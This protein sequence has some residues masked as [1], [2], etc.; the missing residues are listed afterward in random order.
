MN[1]T[2]N[3][4][5]QNGTTLPEQS[6][7]AQLVRFDK[8]LASNG[9]DFSNSYGDDGQLIFDLLF[10][11]TLTYQRD[12]FG[13]GKLIPANFCEAM[14]YNRLNLLKKHPKPA[15]IAQSTQLKKELAKMEKEGNYNK[16][17]SNGEFPFYT[18]LDNA[19]YRAGKENLKFSYDVKNYLSK[20]N[21]Q[22]MKFLPL[23]SDVNK[24]YTENKNK[25]YYTYKLSTTIE[26]HLSKYFMLAS[27]DAVKQLR[28]QNSV[29][30]YFFLKNL[31]QN[32][33]IEGNKIGTPYFD[34]L[35]RIAE[36]HIAAPKDRKKKLIKKL[37]DLREK[38][39]LKFDFRFVKGKGRF[40]YNIEIEFHANAKAISKEEKHEILSAAFEDNYLHGIKNYFLEN[41]H[42]KT[43]LKWKDW[44]SNN[45]Y[46][47]KEK[48]EIFLAEHNKMFRPID[49]HSK[50][51]LT[52]FQLNVMPF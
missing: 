30:L 34:L 21:I 38:T 14:G 2:Q 41:I 5:K 8:N 29:Y 51:V 40:E 44:K 33:R 50:T 19:F 48:V 45:K 46:N 39:D 24:H 3:S 52:Y 4:E 12:L 1:I 27:A 16:K 11:I 26:A 35:C 10:Y 15:Q 47:L 7:Q 17:M 13:Y 22:A 18:V 23:L 20:E 9:L 32:L 43:S 37:N 42:S 25:I 31:Q 36:I 28:Q 49:R 6:V